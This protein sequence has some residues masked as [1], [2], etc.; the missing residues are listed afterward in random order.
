MRKP[1]FSREDVVAAGL[2]LVRREGMALMT[3]RRVADELESSTA[4]VYSNFSPKEVIGVIAVSYFIDK[5]LI[6]KMSIISKMSEEYEQLKLLKNPI[7]IS[8]IVTRIL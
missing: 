5:G 4:P 1:V 7:K 3:A 8:Y 6:E 2:A